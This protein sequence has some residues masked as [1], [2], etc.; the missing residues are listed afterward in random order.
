MH[1]GVEE[2]DVCQLHAISEDG[3][4]SGFGTSSGT[5][6][7]LIYKGVV[8]LLVA[9]EYPL[10]GVLHLSLFHNSR[11]LPGS[12]LAHVRNQGCHDGIVNKNGKYIIIMAG[13]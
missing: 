13:S 7:V 6:A 12:L 11:I 5:A 4:S 8:Y 10:F 1:M 9:S 3:I 2:S